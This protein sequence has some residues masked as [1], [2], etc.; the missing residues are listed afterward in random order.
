M[1]WHRVGARRHWSPVTLFSRT[2]FL[3]LW[4][5]QMVHLLMHKP[6][7]DLVRDTNT[8]TQNS[9]SASAT[10][11]SP[12]HTTAPFVNTPATVLINNPS[13][14]IYNSGLTIFPF[15]SRLI[16]QHTTND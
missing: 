14:N 15:Y 8:L 12:P 5:P 16:R 10:Q 9:S 11:D 7:C 2:A 6:K 3:T 1:V 13:F 4:S